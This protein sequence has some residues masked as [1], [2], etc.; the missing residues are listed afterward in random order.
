VQADKANPHVLVAVERTA[1]ESTRLDV[2]LNKAGAFLVAPVDDLGPAEFHE[3]VAL[4]VRAAFVAPK[5]RLMTNGGQVSTAD[6][7]VF[8]G[9]AFV[10]VEQDAAHRPDQGPRP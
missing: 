3:V 7:A 5:A 10:L 8:P 4:N 6:R 9:F 1:A 2:L